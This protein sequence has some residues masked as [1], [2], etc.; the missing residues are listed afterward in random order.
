MRIEIPECRRC[1]LCVP[2]RIGIIIFGYL[3]LLFACLVLFFQVVYLVERGKGIE[4]MGLNSLYVY[5]GAAVYTQVWLPALLYI[6][7]V[8]FTIVLLV[9]SHTKRVK[10]I[11]AYYYYG[12]ATTVAAI[13]T[14]FVVR[15]ESK[16]L[17]FDVL[18]FSLAFCGFFLHLYLLLLIRSELS[19][20]RYNEGRMS[21]VN[22]ITE[23]T[24]HPPPWREEERM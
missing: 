11:R 14:F 9:G 7:E 24:F 15:Y 4:G 16:F 21:Y 19:K 17:D 23:V 18:E 3:N 8:V 1:C 12:I 22:H 13:M 5:K 20:R 6:L 2:L 10:L